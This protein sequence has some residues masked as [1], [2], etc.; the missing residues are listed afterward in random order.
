MKRAYVDTVEGQ[1]HYRVGGSGEP[2]L[3]LHQRLFSSDEYSK[4]IPIL[5]GC[6]RVVAMDA[7]CSSILEVMKPTNTAFSVLNV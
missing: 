4:V 7:L 2:L 6:C 5:S 3:L 1:I